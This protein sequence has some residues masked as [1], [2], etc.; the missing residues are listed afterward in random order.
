MTLLYQA[1]L[2]LDKKIIVT[3]TI[4]ILCH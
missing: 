4:R 3:E 1:G 2:A